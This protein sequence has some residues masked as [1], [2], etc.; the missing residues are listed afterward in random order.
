MYVYKLRESTLYRLVKR[1]TTHS[2][3]I[4]GKYMYV[5]KY[6][7]STLYGHVKGQVPQV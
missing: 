1:Q 4:T 2:Q 7:D 5:Y 3:L 6:R